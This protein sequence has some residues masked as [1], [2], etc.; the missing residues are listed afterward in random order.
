VHSG[1]I[2][3]R[4]AVELFAAMGNLEP[5]RGAA[6]LPVLIMHGEGDVM[7]AAAGSQ[8]FYEHVGSSDKTLRLYP[9]LY[10]EIFN[11]PE[12]AIRCLANSADWLDARIVH[13]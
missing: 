13:D 11:E 2:T 5:R 1:K 6:D 10:H 12:Q 9:G 4:L 7:A 8:Q 3:A